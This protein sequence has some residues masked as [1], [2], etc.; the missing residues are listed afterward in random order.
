MTSPKTVLIVDDSRLSRMIIK[1]L[2]LEMH[3]NWILLET[4]N[5]E[6][7][8]ALLDSI[9]QP[10]L[11]TLDINMPGMNG[12]SLAAIIR[13]TWDAVPIAVITANVQES[14]VKKC[15]EL[16]VG[17]IEKPI[18]ANSVTKALRFME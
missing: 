16:Q 11:I 9:A 1:A 7:T 12:L 2:I 10:D 6:Q 18:D 15:A 4:T 17:F 3:P 13:E 5:A 8:I 14:I